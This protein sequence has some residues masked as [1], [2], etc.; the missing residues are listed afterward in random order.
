MFHKAINTVEK[1]T[2]DQDRWNQATNVEP[3]IQEF[4]VNI[5]DIFKDSYRKVGIVHEQIAILHKKE[6][7]RR[8]RT[9][10]NKYMKKL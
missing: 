7:E 6:E 10:Q 2:I 9:S 5:V 1:T 3:P 4:M 8:D